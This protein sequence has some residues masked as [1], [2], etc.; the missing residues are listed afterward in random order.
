MCLTSACTQFP[1]YL[2]QHAQMMHI[3]N[4]GMHP[5]ITELPSIFL[6]LQ[7]IRE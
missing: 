3:V 7:L 1:N 6:S 2:L 5:R 4:F